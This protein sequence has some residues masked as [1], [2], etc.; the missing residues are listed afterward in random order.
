MRK[1]YAIKN[2]AKKYKVCPQFG[3]NTLYV[4]LCYYRVDIIAYLSIVMNYLRPI[5]LGFISQ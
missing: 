3:Q 4:L 5:P 2:F 1:I